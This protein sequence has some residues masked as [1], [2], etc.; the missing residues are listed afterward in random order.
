M[1][2]DEPSR[3]RVLVVDDEPLLRHSLRL[4]VGTAPD[5]EVVGEAATGSAA[6]DRAGQL[7]PDVV[8]MDLRMPEVDGVEATRRIVAD[9]AL[10]R[11]RVLVLTM[12][13]LDEYVDAALRAGAS[14]FLL[15]DTE[16]D[17]LLDAVR[18]THAGESL[19]APSVLRRL[20][21]HYLR[22]PRGGQLP[23]GPGRR[24]TPREQEV[25]TLVGG[26]LSNQEIAASL[27]VSMGTVKTHIGSLLAKLHARDRA[28]LVIAAYQA[29]LVEAPESLS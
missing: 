13:E 27:V 9:P 2:V 26:G 4:I 23:Q 10:G 8:L 14:G 7:R 18:R 28:Q 3:I 25:L 24:L 21:Q 20:V 11:T 16:P 6:V 1:T 22:R 15:K 19:F 5:L 29:G 17:Q 12:L